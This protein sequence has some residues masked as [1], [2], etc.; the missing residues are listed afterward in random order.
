MKGSVKKSREDRLR[1]AEFLMK[2]PKNI[3]SISVE[4]DGF[5]NQIF[6][7]TGIKIH[8]G[9]VEATLTFS[10]FWEEWKIGETYEDYFRRIWK[11]KI[12][13]HVFKAA[14]MQAGQWTRSFSLEEASYALQMAEILNAQI[15]HHKEHGKI[16][17]LNTTTINLTF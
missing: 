9:C 17:V 11:E 4:A 5:S 13:N 1:A 12:R 10:L 7:Q 16:W 6:E 2:I 3:S 8:P 14:A 15:N